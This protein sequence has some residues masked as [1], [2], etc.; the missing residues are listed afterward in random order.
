MVLLLVWPLDSVI[1]WLVLKWYECQF[2]GLWLA[3]DCFGVHITGLNAYWVAECMAL[4]HFLANIFS[5]FTYLHFVG[6]NANFFRLQ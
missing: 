5:S 3:L 4:G 6:S 2:A 1:K